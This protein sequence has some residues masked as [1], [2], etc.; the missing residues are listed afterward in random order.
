MLEI[1]ILSTVILGMCLFIVNEV[2]RLR[3]NI[4]RNKEL[5]KTIVRMSDELHIFTET[6]EIFQKNSSLILEKMNKEANEIKIEAE[7]IREFT[8][9]EYSSFLAFVRETKEA[10]MGSINV[11][12][13]YTPVET[14]YMYPRTT[15]ALV[16][17]DIGS[18]EKLCTYTENQLLSMRLIGKGA[19][20][21]IVQSLELKGL[22]LQEV[23][24]VKY[25]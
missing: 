3:V 14:L 7:E 5:N 25:E 4:K 16:Q 11:K 23:T 10:L 12:E 15:A 22:S 2:M 19:L 9:N 18:V 8:K 17:N 1:I 20:Q 6:R 13:K 24:P 21:D